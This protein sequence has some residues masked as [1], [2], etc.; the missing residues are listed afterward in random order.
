[1]SAIVLVLFCRTWEVCSCWTWLGWGCGMELHCDVSRAC[2]T[3]DNMQHSTSNCL[4]QTFEVIDVTA[5]QVLVCVWL[6]S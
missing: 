4:W 2:G 3:A 1:M 6:V 5:M